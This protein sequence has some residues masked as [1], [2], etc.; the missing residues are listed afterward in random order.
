LTVGRKQ[1]NW[2]WTETVS[3]IFIIYLNIKE[4]WTKVVLSNLS[5]EKNEEERNLLRPLD[6]AAVLL[7]GPKLWVKPLKRLSLM[8][9]FL[10]N[11][12][13]NILMQV[14]RL[15]QQWLGFLDCDLSLRTK[16]YIFIFWNI[17]GNAFMET[18]Q[19][20]DQTSKFCIMSVNIPTH[21][22]Q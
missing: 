19:V 15:S 12:Q 22:F 3:F 14:S 13:L 11:N 5:R 2:T 7:E 4:M 1:R 18:E 8:N 6:L 16:H 20:F 17:Y 21:H 10:Q 9:L